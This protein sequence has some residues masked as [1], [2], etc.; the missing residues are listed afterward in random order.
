M[1]PRSFL[2]AVG[3]A[4]PAWPLVRLADWVG[5]SRPA[6]QSLVRAVL[7]CLVITS[8][9]QYKAAVCRVWGSL[10]ASI[11]G[12]LTV[13]QFHLMFYCSRTLPNSLA[14]V[15]V[16]ASLAAWLERRH[17]SF[18]L[19]SAFSILVLRGEL[20]LLLGLVLAG[21]LWSG[22]VTLLRTLQLGI[23]ALV[24]IL[25]IT[26]LLDSWFWQR[27][28]W[29]EAEVM[30]F[31]LVL[32]KSSEWG[33]QPFLWYFYSVLPRALGPALL[34][35][36]P[37]PVLDLRTIPLLLP[38]LA[39]IFLYSFLPHKELR[40]IIY[41]F[42]VLNTAAAVTAARL[43]RGRGKGGRLG[44]LV[45]AGLLAGLAVSLLLSAV[46]LTISR[47]N[48]P[49][50]AALAALHQAERDRPD[51]AAVHLAGLACQTGV[52][53]WQQERQDW[54]YSKEEG[55]LADQLQQFT[56]LLLEAGSRYSLELKPFLHTH[57][58]LAE[59]ESYAGLR[60]NTSRFPAIQIQTKPSLFIL[61]K[62]P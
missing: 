51:S 20:A 41:T 36:P 58:V 21:E 28:L 34:L 3:V 50:G 14:L 7:S 4:V 13:S 60:L 44:R 39:F 54:S 26:V 38:S 22:R 19:F 12:L 16:L 40:F 6:Q 27:W 23:L 53:R 56:H 37:A 48:Y 52:S 32:N 24:T 5:M 30:H 62:N 11:L 9:L 2:G 33:V 59:V 47:Q 46:L 61:K 17:T 15:P 1:V 8:L 42:P 29:P 18:I 43:W 45:G 55:L 25:P 57:T 31:N 49:G 35:V 10:T